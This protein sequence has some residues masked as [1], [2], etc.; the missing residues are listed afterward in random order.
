MAVLPVAAGIEGRLLYGMQ[1]RRVFSEIFIL[2]APAHLIIAFHGSEKVL[3]VS[4]L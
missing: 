2:S 1:K 3:P 4:M